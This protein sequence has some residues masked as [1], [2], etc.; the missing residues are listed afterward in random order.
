MKKNFMYI[1]WSKKKQKQNMLTIQFV[2]FAFDM[3]VA[4]HFLFLK[5]HCPPTIHRYIESNTRGS[6]ST[7]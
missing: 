3:L 6:T 5:S 1:F 2:D 7:R 4:L